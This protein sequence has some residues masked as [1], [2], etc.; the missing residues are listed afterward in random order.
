MDF[1][2]ASFVNVDQYL[3]KRCGT[4]GFVSPEVINV[5]GNQKYNEKADVFS[6][7]IIFHLL[8][9]TYPTNSFTNF[10]G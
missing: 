6:A 1:G 7:G 3:Y 9:Q 4:P 5:E 2:L 8:Y 10:L